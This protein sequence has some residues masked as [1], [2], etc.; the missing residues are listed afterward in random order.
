MG[1]ESL[2]VMKTRWCYKEKGCSWEYV[3]ESDG[4]MKKQTASHGPRLMT[5]LSAVW[6]PETGSDALFSLSSL[7]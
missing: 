2:G 6:C 3:C 4:D 7:S 1:H 5:A